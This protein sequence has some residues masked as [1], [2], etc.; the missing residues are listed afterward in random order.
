M[1]EKL[2]QRQ[3]YILARKGIARIAFEMGQFKDGAIF[4][5]WVCRSEVFK[6]EQAR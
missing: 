4:L 5:M 2:L 3:K 6:N 1:L